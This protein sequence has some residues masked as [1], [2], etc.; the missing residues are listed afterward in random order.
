MI[1]R[2]LFMGV[3]CLA[4]ARA[5]SMR[6]HSQIHAC[7]DLDLMSSTSQDS[8]YIE[9]YEWTKHAPLSDWEMRDATPEERK[10]MVLVFNTPSGDVPSLYCQSVSYKC[11]IKMPKMLLSYIHIGTFN[12]QVQKIICADTSRVYTIVYLSSFPVVGKIEIHSELV[13]N[14]KTESV[15]VVT[16]AQFEIP[17]YLTWLTA[18]SE[19]ILIAS[20]YDELLESV[21]Q[22]CRSSK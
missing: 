15:H 21:K 4:H 3:L 11:D 18:T 1:H 20:Y 8:L 22:M 6:R 16:D 5:H 14:R 17:W 13:G 9:A 2:L 10:R 19:K 7:A 12:G